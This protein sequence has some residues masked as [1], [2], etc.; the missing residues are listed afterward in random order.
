MA[1]VTKSWSAFDD[2]LT[3]GGYG[4]VEHEY[5]FHPTWKFRFD[6]AF[7]DLMI[8]FEYDGLMRYGQNQGHAS[9]G[10]ILSDHEKLNEAQALGWKVFHIN[11]KFIRNGSAFTLADQVLTQNVAP[12]RSETACVSQP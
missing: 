9:I 10:G 11:A 7:P 2:Y 1:T 12:D 5:R 6:W 8:A 4:R 3:L